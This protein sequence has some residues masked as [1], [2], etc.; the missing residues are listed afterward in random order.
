MEG[1]RANYR[2]NTILSIPIGGTW[3]A[4]IVDDQKQDNRNDHIKI[5][6]RDSA[7]HNTEIEAW[8]RSIGVDTLL[9]C[10]IDTSICVESSLRDAFNIGYDVILISNATA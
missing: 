8:L 6:R 9:F 2:N 5:K 1:N 4:E 7:F 10:S 3:D